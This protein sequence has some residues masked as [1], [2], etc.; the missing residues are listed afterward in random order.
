[1][2]RM[3][4]VHGAF[5]G[6]WCW[7]AVAPGLRAAG[8]EVETVALPGSK[9]DPTPV[10]D[11]SLDAYGQRIC[12]ILAEGRPAVLVGHSMGG[13]AITQ[14]AARCPEQ[15]VALVYVAAFLPVDGQ[16]LLDLVAL[17]EGAGDQV[18]ANMVVDE[19]RGVAVLPP[20]GART[21]VYNCCT[22]E[23]ARWAGGMLAPQPLAPFGQ[24][25][26]VPAEHAGAFAGLPRA[27][28]M[29]LQDRA[30]LPAL[31]R[32]ML[33]AGGCDPVIEIDTDHSPWLSTTDELV[34]AL[35]QIAAG[36]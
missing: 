14:A 2:A 28:I 31:Q 7:D 29:C 19:D 9:G 30:I 16:S 33:Q 35:N 11:V 10:A 22:E 25:V 32:R 3:V 4:L 27:Y 15:L 26:R 1:M 24:P 12:E 21:A 17:P 20:A 34:A 36:I 8:H 5:G 6:S 18:Q 23:Q 13:A